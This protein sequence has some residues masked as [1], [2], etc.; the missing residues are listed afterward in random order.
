M[1][2]PAT[3]DTRIRS[4]ND[5]A[6]VATLLKEQHPEHYMVWN[7]S[8]ESYD[9]AVFEDQVVEC[10]YP[11]LP[12]PPLTQMFKMCTSLENWLAADPDNVVAIH[13]MVCVCV[14]A[15][16]CTLPRGVHCR[17]VRV[18]AVTASASRTHTHTHTHTPPLSLLLLRWRHSCRLDAVGRQ[19]WQPAC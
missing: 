13:C 14:C 17:V 19:L 6:A 9:A 1:G 18:C 16:F 7:M 4:R 2:F 8:E 5:A 11:G 15:C 3:P 10:S 12:A